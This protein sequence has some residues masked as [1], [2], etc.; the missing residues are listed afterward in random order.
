MPFLPYRPIAAL[1]TLVLLA[2]PHSSL[3]AQQ[4]RRWQPDT[5]FVQADGGQRIAGIDIGL[6]WDWRWQAT[7]AGGALT[8][9]T[10]LHLGRWHTS[11]GEDFTRVGITP[12]LRYVPRGWSG[13]WFLEAGIGLNA[14]SPRY[15]NEARVFSTS[16]N[17]GD[18]LAVGRRFGAALDQE[19]T[20]R[21]EHL[22]N[23]DIK[24]PNPGENLLQ[25]RYTRRF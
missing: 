9:R 15:R 1:A 5:V 20:L 17:F 10:D 11:A 6:G 2:A 22:S 18:Q 14:L 13:G 23:A 7:L 25:L 16:F 4:D 12:V 21:L 24:R 19:V 8:G 3:H